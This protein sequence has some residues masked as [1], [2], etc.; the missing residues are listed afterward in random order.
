VTRRVHALLLAAASGA[1]AAAPNGDPPLPD[2]LTLEAALAFADAPHPDIETQRVALE[3]ERANLSAVRARYGLTAYLEAVPRWSDP[4][5][6]PGHDLVNDSFA[7]VVLSKKLY[8]FGRT[9][10]LQTSAEATV[11]GREH[12]VAGALTQRRL[13]IMRAFFDVL[14]ADLQFLADDEEMS[15]L[16]VRFDDARDRSELGEIAEVDLFELETRYR[17][18]LDIRAESDARQRFTRAVLALLLNRPGERPANLLR[19]EFEDLDRPTPELED[20]V[21]RAMDAPHLNALR[22]A[23]QAAQSN[24]AAERAARRPELTADFQANAL[25]REIGSRN[26]GV[27][28]VTLRVPIYQGGVDDAAIARAAAVARDREARLRE[29][30]F[31][32]RR[33]VL[34]LVQALDTLRVKRRTAQVREDYRALAVDRARALYELEV[35]TTLGESMARLTE[36]QWRFAQ[37]EFDTALVWAQLSALTGA[38][39]PWLD[40]GA[41]R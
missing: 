37:T 25:E 6:E 19:P 34:T 31:S 40:G 38:A 24:W 33:R 28:G 2:P 36:A 39:N 14:L 20:M 8:D 41:G 7:S 4:A 11:A 1:L 32:T 16:Y 12:L 5:A 13:D 17:E 30:E 15:R 18:A 21:K 22:A 9:R 35:R 23:A 27:L 10:S 3:L 26:Q 29:A